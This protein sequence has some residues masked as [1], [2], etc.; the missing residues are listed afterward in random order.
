MK[1]QTQH[2]LEKLLNKNQVVTHAVEL[3]TYENDASLDRGAPDGVVFPQSADEV[4]RVM[5]WANEH[6]VPLIAR[7]AGTGLSGGAVAEHGGVIVEFSRMTRVS[8]LNLRG[9][10]AVI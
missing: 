2:T 6:N 8:D 7:G 1:S 4:A 5:R 9:K 10:S 3:I